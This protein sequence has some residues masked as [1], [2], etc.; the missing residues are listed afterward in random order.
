MV[1]WGAV[2]AIATLVLAGTTVWLGW[3][4]RGATRVAR[5]ELD[6][7]RAQRR[8]EDERRRDDARR[9]RAMQLLKRVVEARSAL[10]DLVSDLETNVLPSFPGSP[11]LPATAWP[12]FSGRWDVLGPEL[13]T[14]LYI[15]EFVSE[16]IR[17]TARD[18]MAA[19]E[20][21]GRQEKTRETSDAAKALSAT[22][23]QVRESIDAALGLP[24]THRPL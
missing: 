2:T 8:A 4:T 20:R 18:R 17:R 5:D 9:K 10:G 3:Q 22:L 7:L 15:A 13:T 11:R 14:Y 1:D 6:E 23:D 12:H 19:M 16:P 21:I 24:A